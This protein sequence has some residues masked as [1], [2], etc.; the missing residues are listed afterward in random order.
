MRSLQSVLTDDYGLDMTGWTRLTSANAISA[1][2]TKIVGE[3]LYNGHAEAFLVD[4]STPEVPEPG[5][6]VS[7]FSLAA[8]GIAVTAHRKQQKR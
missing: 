7:L 2:G 4:L 6:V 5:V 8:V 3:G 1:D